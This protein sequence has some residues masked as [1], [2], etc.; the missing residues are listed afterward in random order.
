MV[1]KKITSC[2]QH[3]FEGGNIPRQITEEFML[4]IPPLH[5]TQLHQPFKLT[6]KRESDKNK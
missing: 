5:P 4:Y 3:E 6:H 1:P 2:C